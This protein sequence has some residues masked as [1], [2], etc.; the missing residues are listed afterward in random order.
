MMIKRNLI[1][2]VQLFLFGMSIPEAS[3]SLVQKQN[4]SQLTKSSNEIVRG[5][6]ISKFSSW[7]PDSKIIKTY[8]K[9]SIKES[10]K[11]NRS[12]EILF[13][14]AGGEFDGIRQKVYGAAE[15]KMGR[16]AILFLEQNKE[17]APVP[18]G[19]AQGYW[20][21]QTNLKTGKEMVVFSS[22]KNMEFAHLNNGEIKITDKEQSSKSI[23]DM[24]SEIRSAL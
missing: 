12:G 21:I 19:M 8:Y 17:G 1:L 4:I 11:G 9:I 13:V 7:D 15:I 20:E 2:L 5:K 22:P 18:T 23:E 24:Y 6:V 16:E 3:A 10:L 14:Q